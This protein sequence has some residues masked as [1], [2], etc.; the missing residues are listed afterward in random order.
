MPNLVPATR[1]DI[2][3]VAESF[4]SRLGVRETNALTPMTRQYAVIMSN[5]GAEVTR[6]EN[7]IAARI[8]AGQPVPVSWLHR[9]EAYRALIAQSRDQFERFG[10]EL[11]TNLGYEQR[12]AIRLAEQNVEALLTAQLGGEPGILGTFARLPTDAIEQL[13]ATLQPNSPL[14]TLI[15]D[16]AGWGNSV[17]DDALTVGLASGKHP[18]QITK[19]ILSKL[20]VGQARTATIVR[21]EL[22]RSFREAN[23][24]M[25][26]QNADV[27]EKWIWYAHLG[28]Y[29]CAACLAMHGTEHPLDE[30]MGSHPNCFVGDMLVSGPPI[31]GATRRRYSGDFVRV[32]TTTGKQIAVTPN[33]PILTPK[34]WVAAGLLNKGDHVLS[35][36][37]RQ[38]AGTVK[39]ENVEIQSTIK[40]V[41]DTLAH[42]GGVPPVRMPVTAEN[43]HGDGTKEQVD[44]VRTDGFFDDGRF[45]QDG[46]N[47]GSRNLFVNGLHADS[48]LLA[49]QRAT[50]LDVDVVGL[51]ASG[52]M[53]GGDVS[54]VF[55]GGSL[56]SHEPVSVGQTATRDAAFLQP[57]AHNSTAYPVPT[58]EQLFR[59][60]GY[61]V[62]DQV[63]N[64]ERFNATHDVYNLQ[65]TDEWYIANG[66]I[67]HNCRCTMLPKTPSWESL[68]FPN[69]PETRVTGADVGNGEEWL[70]NQPERVQRLAFGNNKVWRGWSDGEF[71]LRDTIRRTDSAA[72]GTTRSIAGYDRAKAQAAA[73]LADERAAA[74]RLA[75]KAKGAQRR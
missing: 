23:R 55:C 66:I 49:R 70:R 46:F 25:M 18:N 65:T 28:G 29:T 47:Q 35:R 2:V 54:C 50:A 59:Y 67:A 17:I 7:R 11:Y 72:W 61:V 6:L 12:A 21:T 9:D 44:I 19:D 33:H 74:Q 1:G 69:V 48:L 22:Y 31:V 37:D 57:M 62:A 14:R 4:R 43:F 68:G 8:A 15:G 38:R 32:V 34:G 3:R 13:T 45:M 63:V 51:P 64:V 56:H 36:D 75:R 20:E 52:G 30:P 26:Q 53:G 24:S 5:L 42:T 41:F 10:G 58:R 71:Q 27:T 60:A 39:P 40:Q 16:F 73:R